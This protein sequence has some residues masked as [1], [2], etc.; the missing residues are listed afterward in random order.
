M[1]RRTRNTKMWEYLERS[2]VLENGTDEQIKIAKR[3]YRK[4]YLLEYKQKQR[5]IKP[6]YHIIFSKGN[7]E[8]EK[9]NRAAKLHS[10]TIT[11]FV[12]SAVLAYISNTYVVPD[13]LQIARLEQLL[14]EC[15]N[16]IKTIVHI[17][18]KYFWERDRK[19][20]AIEKR[21]EKLEDQINEVLRNPP[22]LHDRQNQIA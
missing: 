10:M 5:K 19:I 3:S 1:Q 4:K 18:E 12:H 13:K 2:G 7:G 21:I 17:K 8:Y 9:V 20:D 15:L 11:G 22:L 6:E 14:S 16:E